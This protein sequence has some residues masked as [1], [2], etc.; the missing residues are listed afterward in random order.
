MDARSEDELAFV[1]GHEFGHH[2]ATHIQ[3][4]Q[5]QAMVGAIALGTLTAV[6]QANNQYSDPYA[7]QL[8]IESSMALGAA[9]GNM[10]YS[11]AYELE[12]DVIGTYITRSA[13][14][15]PV[16]GAKFFAR[17]EPVRSTDGKLSFWGTH[18]PDS[19]RLATVI[20]TVERIEAP[21][22]E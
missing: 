1:M 18:P 7:D 15:D 17:P 3:K 2:I 14:Y 8:A 4:Q 16:K 13:G 9:L 6:A 19:K 21:T 12:A 5:Q 10:A 20:A 22:E 11:Q